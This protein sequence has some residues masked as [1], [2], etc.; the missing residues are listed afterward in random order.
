MDERCVIGL[1][2]M[3]HQ[4]LLEDLSH[5]CTLPDLFAALGRV[6]FRCIRGVGEISTLQQMQQPRGQVLRSIRSG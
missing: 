5:D 4:S 1:K 2:Y 6:V 3:H